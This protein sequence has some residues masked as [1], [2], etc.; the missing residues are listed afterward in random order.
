MKLQNLTGLS[1]A[2]PIHRYLGILDRVLWDHDWGDTR[3][4]P[5]EEMADD[6]WTFLGHPTV[7]KEIDDRRMD[8]YE[9]WLKG[10]EPGLAEIFQKLRRKVGE[11]GLTNK[12]IRLV[13]IWIVANI[14][15]LQEK[16]FQEYGGKPR[17][18]T[19][20]WEESQK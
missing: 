1:D 14:L 19:S 5:Q 9:A 16:Y 18:I 11:E 8:N 7:L 3:G 15:Y 6:I 10:R 13:M 4:T 12:G 20:S 2:D 17:R